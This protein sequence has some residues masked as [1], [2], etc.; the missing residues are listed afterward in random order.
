MSD[1]MN[2]AALEILAQCDGYYPQY[3]GRYMYGDTCPGLV[4]KTLGDLIRLDLV[5][6]VNARNDLT[7]GAKRVLVGIFASPKTD[8]MGKDKIVYWPALESEK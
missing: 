5:G 4:V 7:D 3:S 1:T 6:K 8:D 2:D